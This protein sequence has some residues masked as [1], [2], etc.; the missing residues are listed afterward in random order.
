MQK[1]S[2]VLDD[3]PVEPGILRLKPGVNLTTGERQFREVFG[4]L[5]SLER[6]VLV[7][8]SSIFACDLAFQ[9]GERENFTRQIDVT[10]PVVNLAV[11]NHVV[12]DLRYALY[13]LSNDAWNLRFVQQSGNPETP[14]EWPQNHEGKVLLFSGGL[15]SFAAAIHYGDG[16]GQMQLVSHITANRVVSEAQE[17]LFNYLDRQYSRQFCRLAFR[18]GGVSKASKGYPFPS[19]QDREETQRTRSFLFLSLAALV[20]R[21]NGFRDV[22]LIAEN[23]QMSIHLPLTAA[24]ISAF[25]T[26]TA[27]P[28][29]VHIIAQ[30]LSTL[31]AYPIRIENPFLYRTKAEVIQTVVLH[32]ST[33]VGATVSCWKASRLGNRYNHCGVCIPCLVRR[34]AV[35]AHGVQ[36]SEYKRNLMTENVAALHPDDEGKRNLVELAEFITLFEHNHPQAFLE[37]VYPDLINRY[38]DATKAVE[39]YRRFATEARAVFNCYPQLRDF[40]R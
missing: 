30:I 26:H 38:I 32:H 28:E 10:I 31:L 16:G 19:D 29:F 33:M 39:M 15:D 18:V 1:A 12:E 9:R 23:G 8:A 5:T 27:H 11:F 25:S 17:K 4:K 3:T 22:V 37:D 36:L 6:D 35:E 7:V 20:A 14:C 24:R 21:R 34:I 13:T 2:V 40:L